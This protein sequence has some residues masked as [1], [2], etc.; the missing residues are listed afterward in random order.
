MRQRGYGK[1]IFVN[2]VAKQSG[3]LL[4]E[5]AAAYGFTFV[6]VKGNKMISSA[7]DQMFSGQAA[8]VMNVEFIAYLMGLVALGFIASLARDLSASQFSVNIQRQ[9]REEA[10][11]KLMRMEMKYFDGHASGGVLNKM[12]ADLRCTG[13]FFSEIFPEI[14]RILVESVVIML[15]I[16]EMDAMLIVFL[17]VSYP[18]VLIISHFCSKR[19]AQLMENRWDKIDALNDL[20]YDSIQGIIVGRSF[21]LLP[22]MQ[23]KIMRANKDILDFE[24]RRNKLSSVAWSLN[25]I[26]N[27]LPNLILAALALLRVIGGSLTIGEMTYFVLMLE[28]M[29]HPLSELPSLFNEAREIGVSMK[30]LEELMQQREESGGTFVE[31]NRV[32]DGAVIEF[33]DISFSYSEKNKVLDKVSFKIQEGYHIAFA[34]SSGGGKSTLFKLFCGFYEKQSG[35]YRLYGRNFEEWDL[36]AARKLFALVS[37]NVFLF[38]G[39][40][41]EN[42]T[43]GRLDADMEEVQQACLNANIHDFIM[44]LP[45]QYETVVGERGARLSGGEKQRLSIARAFLK[46]APILLLDEPTSAIDVGTEEL[47]KEALERI[48]QGRTVITIA[49]RLSTIEDADVIMV[50][51]EG[52]IAQQGTHEELLAQEG[53]YRELYELQKQGED[54][55]HENGNVADI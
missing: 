33:Q 51:A 42:V 25:T 37:Q 12:I 41:A 29:I 10:G 49:H 11:N 17:A 19:L 43:Y 6:V 14:C 55:G 13:G 36:E 48:A 40:I 50:L 8:T 20:A 26:I 28:R 44:S 54:R 9:F 18:L 3:W 45:Q 34:G 7:I 16:I 4:A 39:T 23:K 22:V 1:Y 5:L 30:R 35:T 32:E 53:I 46:N 27:W 52:K 38:P 15:S 2:L 24:F 21:N 47:I 31:G